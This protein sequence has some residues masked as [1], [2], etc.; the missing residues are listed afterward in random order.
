MLLKQL[1]DWSLVAD[2]DFQLPNQ[3]V[4]YQWNKA[5]I[6]LFK[7]LSILDNVLLGRAYVASKYKTSIPAIIVE[8]DGVERIGTGF[9]V[10]NH[11]S[12]KHF[13][14]NGHIFTA[15]HNVDPADGIRLARFETGTPIEFE[16]RGDWKFHPTLDIAAMQVFSKGAIPIYPMGD[17]TILS[18]TI[19]LGYPQISTSDGPSLLAHSGE[20]NAV[21]TSYF[22]QK[23]YLIVSNNVSP[24][25]SGGPV[26]NDAGL[27]V[28]MVI[29]SL[30]T[31][32]E[33][34]ITKANAAIPARELQDFLNPL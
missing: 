13:D 28:G 21:I 18:R 29:R 31:E 26:L 27:C 19:S 12:G 15:R 16:S 8:K 23:Q 5:G 20:L 17:A 7:T 4:R 10:H 2:N 6:S 33:G 30:E 32:H 22:D 24:G 9:L 25:N 3:Y 11:F 14:G 34:G 1:V